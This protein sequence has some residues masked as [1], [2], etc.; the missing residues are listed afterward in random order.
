MCDLATDLV[1]EQ[2]LADRRREMDELVRFLAARPARASWRH[3][4]GLRM[5]GLGERLA[6]HRAWPHGDAPTPA[7]G[8]N[9]GGARSG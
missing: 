2:R 8:S 4:L 7:A 1:A 9:P 6:G 3:W 5:I